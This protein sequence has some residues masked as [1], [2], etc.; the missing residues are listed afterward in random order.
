MTEATEAGVGSATAA[1]KPVKGL[2]PVRLATPIA[3]STGPFSDTPSAA[4]AEEA[5]R[6]AGSELYVAE[7][8]T[9]LDDESPEPTPGPDPNPIDDPTAGP[10]LRGH[11]RVPMGSQVQKMALPNRPGFHRHWFNDKPGRIQA[12]INAG[13]AHIKDSS[14]RPITRIVGVAERGGGLNAYAMEV[15]LQW[16]EE[17]QK[18]K[19]DRLDE[20]DKT[21]QRGAFRV[22]PGDRRY[23]PKSTPIKIKSISGGGPR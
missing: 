21:I 18:L 11:V 6:M 14:G 9:F 5:R 3:P 16:H 2:R 19:Q 13:Y 12:A 10:G 4:D 23:V 20:E 7:E 15:P 17:Y 8:Q 22:E 1:P